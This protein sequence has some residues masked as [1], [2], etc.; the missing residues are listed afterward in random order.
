MKGLRRITSL[1]PS[2]IVVVAFL[3]FMQ[4]LLP[5]AAVPSYIVP[6]PSAVFGELFA[7]NIPWG[8]HLWVTLEE[9]LAGFGLAILLGIGLAI[10]IELSSVLSRV[11]QP[12]IV[13]AQVIPKV[14][15]APILF[16]WL[17]LNLVPRILTVFLVCFFPVVV[18][19]SAGLAS[20]DPDMLNLVRAFDSS[21]LT[22]LR[23]VKFPNALP[24]IFAGLKVAASLAVV[25][26]VVSEFIWSDSGLGFLIVSSQVSLNAPLMFAATA[27]L[28]LE[29]F[30]LYGFVTL[31]ESVMVP[32]RSAKD[33]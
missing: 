28:I 24:N 3:V 30:A 20:A 10:L 26:S 19:T 27:L 6:L 12:I 33:V 5:V 32:W 29:G 22:V 8:M 18:D 9:T 1:L 14:A 4:L 31:M 23:K 13:A 25:G 15:L 17:G 11:I 21:R 16:L 7:S 2:I